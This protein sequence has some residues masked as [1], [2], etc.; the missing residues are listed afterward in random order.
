MKEFVASLFS[1]FLVMGCNGE[2]SKRTLWD[3]T[4][5]LKGSGAEEVQMLCYHVK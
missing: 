3:H 4:V 2:G 5:H 1:L